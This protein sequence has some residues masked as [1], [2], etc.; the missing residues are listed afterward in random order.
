MNTRPLLA[1][2]TLAAATSPDLGRSAL[3]RFKTGVRERYEEDPQGTVISA[4]L[5]GAWLFYKAE[6]GHNPKVKSFYDAL[7]YVSTNLSV[8]YCDI[9]AVTPKGKAIGSVLMMYGPAMAAR[10]LDR[11]KGVKPEATDSVNAQILDRLDRILVL[12]EN[13]R[14]ASA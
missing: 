12:L 11:P 7:V 8:G 2:A 6:Q 14:A 9:L 4:V 3:E 10:M 1:L 5:G 13:A